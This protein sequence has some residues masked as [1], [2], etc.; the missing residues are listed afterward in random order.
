M[1]DV[2]GQFEEARPGKAIQPRYGDLWFLYRLVRNRQPDVLLE[3]GSGSS[4]VV[5]AEAARRNGRGHVWSVESDRE[6]AAI[7]Q[8]AMP[9]ALVDLVTLVATQAVPADREVPGWVHEHVPDIEPDL[10]YLDGPPLTSERAVAF[11]P[12]DLESRFQPGFVMVVDGRLRNARYLRRYLKRAYRH[13]S[14][15][16]RTVFELVA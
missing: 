16:H 1:L 13:R 7:T 2:I 4:T 14:H 5:L 10:L 11:D 8:N 6:W 12:I 15:A 9:P 3:F